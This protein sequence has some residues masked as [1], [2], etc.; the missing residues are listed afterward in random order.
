M[1][2]A[3]YTREEPIP[4]DRR[5]AYRL[6]MAQTDGQREAVDIVLKEFF[7]ETEDGWVNHR[8]EEEILKANDKKNKASASAEARWRNA[9]E[10]DSALPSESGRNANAPEDICERIETPCEGNA[11]NPNPNPNPKVNLK[12][13]LSDTSD[14]AAKFDRFWSAYPKKQAKPNALKAW[15]SAKPDLDTVLASLERFKASEDWRK[16]GGRYIPMPATWLNQRRWEDEAARPVRLT[17]VPK[18]RMNHLG[19]VEEYSE[20][21]GIKGWSATDFHS[22]EDY[23]A[24]RCAA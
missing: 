2:D 16:D 23:E 19:F 10:K 7:V 8:C 18:Y 11:P 4:L 5:Q 22:I 14:V 20:I 3:Y 13:L 15:R 6:V 24:A 12:T 9:R 17:V 1:L 21:G